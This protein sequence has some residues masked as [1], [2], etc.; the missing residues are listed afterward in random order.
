MWSLMKSFRFEASH[1]LPNHDGKCAKLHGHSWEVTIQVDGNHLITDGAK[2]GMLMDYYDLGEA[3]RP[4][5]QKLDHSHLNDIIPNP[6]SEML[7]VYIYR[8]L[9]VSWPE[10]SHCSIGAIYISETCTSECVYKPSPAI[11]TIERVHLQ[12]GSQA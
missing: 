8:Q 5:I 2:Q 12:R 7:C 11:E 10:K 3:M 1:Q 9:L 4:I 6:T